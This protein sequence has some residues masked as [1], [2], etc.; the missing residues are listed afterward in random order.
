M[1][2]D[3]YEEIQQKL[4]AALWTSSAICDVSHG[5]VLSDRKGDLVM[6]INNVSDQNSRCCRDRLVLMLF[7]KTPEKISGKMALD[8]FQSR[9]RR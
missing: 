9:N 4:T 1:R 8:R 3:I 7:Y 2:T 6:G 5:K